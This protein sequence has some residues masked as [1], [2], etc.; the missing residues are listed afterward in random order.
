MKINN[1]GQAAL[2]SNK[3]LEAA[4]KTHPAVIFSM[5]LPL[6]GYMLFYGKANLHLEWGQLLLLFFSGIVFWSFFEYIAHRYLFHLRF[7]HPAVQRMVYLFHGNHHEFPRDKSRLLMP[8]IPSILLSSSIFVL[9]YAVMR[10]NAVAFFPGFILGYL[11]YGG[12]H[13]A[14]HAMAPPFPW[15]KPLWRNHTLHHYKNEHFGFGVSSTLWDH[16]FGTAFDLSK[17][18]EDKEKVKELMFKD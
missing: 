15:L 8:P 9:L 4:T 11:I 16:V 3:Y 6:I 7:N 17:H 2:F 10:L 13:Y 14:I 5:Y 18:K 12:M 1:K